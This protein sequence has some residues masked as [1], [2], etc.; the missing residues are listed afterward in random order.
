MNGKIKYLATGHEVLEILHHEGMVLIVDIL[1][2]KTD[3]GE[4]T[5]EPIYGFYR[6]VKPEELFVENP[7]TE[8]VTNLNKLKNEVAELRKEK[9]RLQNE[10]EVIKIQIK[11]QKPIFEYIV[12]RT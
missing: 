9:T 6:F 5:D 3:C 10:I 4:L 11:N 2:Y 12:E 1:G 8:Y 7:H